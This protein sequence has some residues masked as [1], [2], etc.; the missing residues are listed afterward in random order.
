MNLIQ[1]RMRKLG[2][3]QTDLI[4]ELGKQHI[5]VQ[6]PE[7]SYILRGINTTP[8]AKKVLD[9]CN[10]IITNYEREYSLK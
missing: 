7:M 10:K 9:E 6:P 4:I 3:K 8:K 2:I 5:I 1:E